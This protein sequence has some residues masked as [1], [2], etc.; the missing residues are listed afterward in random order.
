[1][2]AR[3]AFVATGEF[4]TLTQEV[5]D[6]Y[7]HYVEDGK[8]KP[9]R[10][11]A[12]FE[13]WMTNIK[14]FTEQGGDGRFS[15]FAP[16]QYPPQLTHFADA[17]LFVMRFTF[18]DV[19]GIPGDAYHDNFVR[20]FKRDPVLRRSWMQVLTAMFAYL[21]VIESEDELAAHWLKGE[22]AWCREKLGG[23]N[24]ASLLQMKRLVDP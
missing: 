22:Y 11:F 4:K 10:G 9:M 24:R 3:G 7:A 13:K 14:R 6:F 2:P 17:F 19:Q 16:F 20:T 12:V 8:K 5:G 1:M 18:S 23:D 21:R 15:N